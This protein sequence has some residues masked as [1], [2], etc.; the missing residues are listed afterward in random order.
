M[1]LDEQYLITSQEQLAGIYAPPS[2]RALSKVINYLD[3]YCRDFIAASPFVLLATSGLDGGDCSP[4]GDKKGF[5]VVEDTKT[6]L[7][8]DRPGNNRVDSIK[9]IVQNPAVALLFL[10][11]GINIVLRVNGKAQLSIAPD[12]LSRFAVEG[13]LPKAVI[14]ITAEQIFIQCPRALVRSD[15]WNPANHTKSAE[16]PSVG[17][18]L[19]AHTCGK[20]NAAEYDAQEEKIL[21]QSLY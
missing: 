18:I 8:P 15:L 19:A 10:V 21:Y 12:L 1:Q 20:V 7:L 9:N 16:M 17:A 6:L 11:P 2:E 4:R 3:S 13:K 14:A 5:V